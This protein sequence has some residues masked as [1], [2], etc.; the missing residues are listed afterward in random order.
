MDSDRRGEIG[1]AEFWVLSAEFWVLSAEFE[2][3]EK[4]ETGEIKSVLSAGF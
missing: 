1:S 3:G 4:S 2:A